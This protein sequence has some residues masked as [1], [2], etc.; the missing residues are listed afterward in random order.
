MFAPDF[1]TTKDLQLVQ[2][3]QIFISNN[4]GKFFDSWL[5]MI[6]AQTAQKMQPYINEVNQ[7]HN[8]M[9]GISDVKDE[10]QLLAYQELFLE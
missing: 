1:R 6:D 2:A 7:L 10:M 5:S 4:W 8:A 3:A 9:V